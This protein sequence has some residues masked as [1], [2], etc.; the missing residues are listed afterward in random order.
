M[1]ILFITNSC[2]SSKYKEISNKR[3][4]AIIDPQQKYFRLLV[5]GLASIEGI[6]V[7]VL[8]VLPLSASS[9]KQ[10]I[11]RHE[12]EIE[13][14]VHY[15]Y[16]G[17]YN[18]KLLRYITIFL[19][20]IIYV[21]K[22]YRSLSNK[23]NA[24]LITDPLMMMSAVPARCVCKIL[25]ITTCALITD[26]PILVSYMK[27]DK[28]GVRRVIGDI[29]NILA[30]RD[31]SKYDKYITL[32]ESINSMINKSNKPYTIIEGV[33]DV[34]D[35]SI[36]ESYS[37][38]V[39]Y[40]GGI[41]EMYGVKNLVS[42]FH[43]L[44]QKDVELHLYGSGTF[45]DEIMALQAIDPRVQY[46][47]CLSPEE[48]VEKEKKALLLVNPRPC[49]EEFSK[50]S[51]PSKT[52]EYM[53]SGTPVVSTKLPGIPE[54]YFDYIFTFDDDSEQAIYSKLTEIIA[55]DRRQ[56]R[57]KGKE[58]HDFVIGNKNNLIMARK[59]IELLN[60]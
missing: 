52:M 10:R 20:T 43:M 54:E 53:L 27:Q 16:M 5:E 26:L 22:W 9:Y 49:N 3:T 4:R 15:E 42:A 51:F 19:N 2:S 14:G 33:A 56:L 18:G 40:A 17:F 21:F 8:P 48:I 58:A 23:K 38:I 35:T 44:E 59:V 31:I 1:D 30:H 50:Y 37:N 46:K 41:Y 7:R 39:L 6:S 36:C 55:L 32:T 28:K 12:E 11:F 47:G 24:F 34:T 45:V 60:K 13:N 57:S 29:Y 25:G